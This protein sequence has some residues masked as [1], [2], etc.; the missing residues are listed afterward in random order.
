MRIEVNGE[1][2][3]IAKGTT[4]LALLEAL[5]LAGQLVAVERNAEIVPRAEHARAQV[6]DGD[7]FEIVQFV[8]GG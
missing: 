5:G 3:E 2:R 4:V 1:A 6:Q 7:R 8:G